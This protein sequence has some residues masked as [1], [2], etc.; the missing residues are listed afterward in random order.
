VP[1]LGITIAAVFLFGLVAVFR[2]LETGF[3][4]TGGGAGGSRMAEGE[5]ILI[6]SITI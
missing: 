6:V 2:M 5:G 4:D 1:L 3:L